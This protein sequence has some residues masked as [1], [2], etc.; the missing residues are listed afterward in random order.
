MILARL[1]VFA[2]GFA[3]LV[4]SYLAAEGGDPA[5]AGLL[6]IGGFLAVVPARWD[7]AIMIKERM[8]TR[9]DHPES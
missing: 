8:I 5:A 4:A 3:L 9:G 2:I 7:P 1:I 6:M